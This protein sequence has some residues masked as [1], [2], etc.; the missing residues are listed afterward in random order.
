MRI[1]A[2]GLAQSKKEKLKLHNAIAQ[3]QSIESNMRQQVTQN[4]INSV[5]AGLGQMFATT[6]EMMN[7]PSYK[8]AIRAFAMENEQ[9]V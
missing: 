9:L 6:N 5:Y 8:A 1:Y 7:D 3:L 2:R 4:K